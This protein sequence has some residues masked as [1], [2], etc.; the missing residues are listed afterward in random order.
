[1]TDDLA[2]T[3]LRAQLRAAEDERDD[4]RERLAHAFEEIRQLCAR[5]IG[6]VN[7]GAVPTEASPL[8]PQLAH[9]T[10]LEFRHG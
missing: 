5:I 9:R 7:Q 4:L 6:T 10:A 1:M 8:Q 3:I 2:T